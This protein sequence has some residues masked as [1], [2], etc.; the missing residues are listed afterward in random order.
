MKCERIEAF[1]KDFSATHC[2]NPPV[3]PFRRKKKETE[4]LFFDISSRTFQIIEQENGNGTNIGE[5]RICFLNIEFFFPPHSML[6]GDETGL[7]LK[8]LNYSVNILNSLS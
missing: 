8:R 4:K 1:M 3:K 2:L 7:Y 5:K 6:K